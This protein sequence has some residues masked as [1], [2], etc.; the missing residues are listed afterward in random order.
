MTIIK[1]P[2]EHLQAEER[3]RGPRGREVLESP[4]LNK[5]SAFTEGERRALGLLG[6]L[7]PHVSTPDE[8]LAR[9][10]ENLQ[11]KT[12]SLERYIFLASLQDRNETLFYRL[13]Q[14]AHHRDDADR[15]YADGRRGL[16]APTATSTAGRAACSFAYPQRDESTRFSP[17]RRSATSDVIVVTDGERILGLGDLGVGGMGIPIGKLSLYTLCAGIHPATTLPILLD[18]GT[19]QPGAARRSAVPRLAARAAPRRRTTTRSSTRSSRR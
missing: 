4:L 8:Q 5:G 7:P 17:M 13:L 15:L 14:R 2:E 10:Y 19:E 1:I 12:S 6:L 3:L 11:R 18:V 9:A 16:P